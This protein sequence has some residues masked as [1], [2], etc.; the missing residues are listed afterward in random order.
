MTTQRQTGHISQEVAQELLEA[1][2]NILADDEI[3]DGSLSKVV[4]D[5]ANKVI[6]KA[7]G[8]TR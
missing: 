6:A 8:G 1:L 3:S 4:I 5:H 2:K 7:E